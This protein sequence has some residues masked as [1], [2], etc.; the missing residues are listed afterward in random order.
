M[1]VVL[2]TVS[3]SSSHEIIQQCKQQLTTDGNLTFDLYSS[4]HVMR[5]RPV[6]IAY[7]EQTSVAYDALGVRSSSPLSISAFVTSELLDE[8]GCTSKID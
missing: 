5:A 3:Q 2:C 7:C 6:E 4:V 8:T 1:F